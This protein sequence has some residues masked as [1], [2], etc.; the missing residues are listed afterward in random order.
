MRNQWNP[1]NPF[2]WY[3]E[4]LASHPVWRDEEGSV[5]VFGYDNVSTVL[6][7]Y[8]RFSSNFGGD[9]DLHHPISQSLIATDPP[10]HR[11]LRAL[12]SQGFTPKTITKLRP[13]I[14]EIASELVDAMAEPSSD[15]IA[16]LAYP[17]P[18]I[19]IAELL[20][21]PAEDREQFK[22][23]SDAMVSGVREAEQSQSVQ[24]GAAQV[25]DPQREMAQ[26]F[27]EMIEWRRKHPGQDLISDLLRA[28]LEGE[29]LTSGELL[30]FCV[31]L[32]VAGNETTT[33][34]I[35]NAVDTLMDH[36]EAFHQGPHA[37]E[38]WGPLIEEVL[39]FR[40]PVQ[41]M[42]RICRVPTQLGGVEL[43][44][45]D[46]LVAW[47]GAAN[48]DPSQFK[49]PEE[50]LPNRAPNRHIAFGHGVHFCLGAPLARLEASIGLATLY[51]RFPNLVRANGDPPRPVP[52]SIVYGKEWLP[53]SLR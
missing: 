50:F 39:R 52:S 21:V 31:L 29:H 40:S 43:A 44:P 8:H 6:S 30:G 15:I 4:M 18:V 23:W 45:K 51:T 49:D 53:A 33:N 1:G 25:A 2:P 22:R 42:Y 24:A 36:P 47:I 14:Q 3:Q 34:L 26:Y 38:E 19:V 17:L 32:L 46:P 16:A 10:R 5:H 9:D 7:D 28:T 35:G 11:A 48:H 27:L 20:G 37:P 41:S 12:V 13:R